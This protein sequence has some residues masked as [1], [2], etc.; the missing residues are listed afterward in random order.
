MLCQSCGKNT[1]T[2]FIQRTVNGKTTTLHLC[3]DCAAKQG[4][5]LWNGFNLGD[6]WGNLFA[7]P[8]QRAIADTV[9][10]EGCGHSF[11]EIAQSGRA[12]CPL[13]YTT[14]YDRLLPS[15]ERIHGKAHH[16][17]KAPSG[18]GAQMRKENELAQLKQELSESIARQ[19][20]EKCAQLR[21]RIREMEQSGQI[22][23]ENDK[24]EG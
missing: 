17:G 23:Q 7:E 4:I 8:S 15:I 5:S 19:E 12:G 18:A 2:T 6:F 10:C 21:D 3:A 1:A 14:F 20:Y 22:V 9:R 13:C 16:V 24:Q 11:Q